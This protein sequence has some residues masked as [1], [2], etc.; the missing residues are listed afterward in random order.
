GEIGNGSFGRVFKVYSKYMKEFVALKVFHN[1]PIDFDEN[2]FNGF[3]REIKI[4][5][6]LDHKNIIRFFG[7][8]QG[9]LTLCVG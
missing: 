9:M 1:D 8:T 7:I 4:V 2:L 5:T 6:P 3:I